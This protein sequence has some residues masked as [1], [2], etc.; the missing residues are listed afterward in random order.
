MQVV[1]CGR[2]LSVYCIVDFN[3]NTLSCSPVAF[4]LRVTVRRDCY[5]VLFWLG[6][7]GRQLLWTQVRCVI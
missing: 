6:E 4:T 3:S 1:I 2:F 5:E 7:L